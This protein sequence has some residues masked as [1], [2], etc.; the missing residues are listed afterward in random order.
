MYFTLLYGFGYLG[1]FAGE[2]GFPFII[3]ASILPPIL[4]IVSVYKHRLYKAWEIIVCYWSILSIVLLVGPPI[5]YDS[6]LAP[7][8]RMFGESIVS[9]IIN[10]IICLVF[11]LIFNKKK[12]MES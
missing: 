3:A 6:L 1:Y 5:A 4:G 11:L 2:L 10:Y 8:G 12:G 7:F 9:V